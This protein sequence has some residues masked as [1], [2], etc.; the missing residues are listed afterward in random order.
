M[1]STQSKRVF[2]GGLDKDT[3]LR[4]LKNGDYHHALN[5]RNVSSEAN[6]EGVIE[7]IKGNKKATYEFP[8]N[9]VSGRRRITLFMP[10]FNYFFNYGGVSGL[11]SVSSFLCT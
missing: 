9:P 5:I 2:V 11:S 7:N 3:D 6:T 8:S 1:P 10:M 4:A